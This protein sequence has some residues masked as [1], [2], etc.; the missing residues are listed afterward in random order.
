MAIDG[1]MLS[2]IKNDL[3]NNLINGR[4]KKIYQ[5]EKRLLNFNLRQPGKNYRL[6]ISAHP[7]KA[8]VHISNLSFDNPRQPPTFCMLLR[9]YLS[10]GII[11]DVTQPNFE[12]ILNILIENNN[13]LYTLI[14][15]IMGRYSNV[16]LIDENNT[17][18]DS[19]IRI[20]KKI[21]RE[22]NLYPGTEYHLPP[23]QDKLNP[24]EVSKT[25]FFAKIPADF[26]KYCFKA[27]LFNFRGI[28]PDLA[29]EIIYRADV[30]YEKHYINL[31]DSEKEKIWLSFTEIFKLVK[32]NNFTPA[33]GINNDKVEYISAF[34]LKHLQN[35]IARLTKFNTTGELFD[36]YYDNFIKDRL[37]KKQLK[38]L[39][40]IINNFLQKNRKK[41]KKL[42]LKLNSG[43]QADKFKEKGELLKAN[44]F[45]MKKGMKKITVNNFYD[46]NNNIT[47]K[48]DPRLSP[49][50]N[51]QKYFKKYNKHRKSIKHIKR[52]LGK[53]RHEERYL[54][55]VL[56]NIEQSTSEEELDQVERELRDEGYIKKKRK[57]KS[58]KKT[59]SPLPPRK[60]KSSQGYDI[61]VGRNNHQNDKLTKKIANNHDIWL[62]TK[63]IAGSHV[64]IRAQSG[65]N[66][67]EDTIKEAARLAAFYSKGRMS[68]NV[69]VD[70][71]EVK[72]VNK[73]AGA[74]PGL[75]YYDNYQT[76]YVDPVDQD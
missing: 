38:K 58:N 66:I 18:L 63:H 44:I 32:N 26:A 40:D 2:N 11:K 25:D 68:T 21:S 65:Q 29:K 52:E 17:V 55:Q 14:L 67:P 31:S 71:T 7:Q 8:R 30:D 16:I 24:L 72:N 3:N 76:I 74:K 73:P 56:V 10:G 70:F 9:K 62:H 64:I 4:I 6:L 15:E 13:K 22:R 27:I 36:Y 50:E 12:R 41:Q 49:S 28:G 69:P 20:T 5:P 33:L 37:F 51:I 34:P 75:V 35:D 60:Y 47:I 45:N 43:L 42:K 19:M 54:D 57:K 23:A 48:L 1:V 46:E 61:L 39:T 53:F 59:N